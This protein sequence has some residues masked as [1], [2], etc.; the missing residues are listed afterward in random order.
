M[1]Q[2]VKIS[3]D[4]IDMMNQDSTLTFFPKYTIFCVSSKNIN[5]EK[6]HVL[7]WFSLNISHKNGD[8]RLKSMFYFIFIKLT[9]GV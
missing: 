2:T 7:P 9:K 3:Y 5:L 8:H 4:I 6:K 1:T